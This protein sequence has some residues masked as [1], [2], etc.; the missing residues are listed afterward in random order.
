M[1]KINI[2]LFDIST[3][4]LMVLLSFLISLIIILRISKNF[5]KIDIVCSYFYNI[6]GFIIGAKIVYFFDKN[7]EVHILNSGYA[8]VGGVIGGIIAIFIYSKQFK[9]D[10]KELLSNY[11][12]IYPLIYSISKIGCF[13]GG[14]C[15]G[16]EYNGL[17]H[18]ERVINEQIIEIFPIQIVETIITFILFLI[19]LKYKKIKSIPLFLIGF[20]LFRFL[21]DYFRYSRNTLFLNFTISQI[22]CISF[23]LIG[24][25]IFVKNKKS[26]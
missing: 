8:F 22:I 13:L 6:V 9:L 1:N 20:G 12:I 18:I 17:F 7:M 4:S 23:I 21:I 25:Y 16:K 2:W 3:Y 26:L 15:I 5:K 10:N 24:I 14:C 19:L 11:V